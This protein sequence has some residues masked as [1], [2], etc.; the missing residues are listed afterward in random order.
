[1][2]LREVDCVNKPIYCPSLIPHETTLVSCCSLPGDAVPVLLVD[3]EI[4]NHWWRRNVATVPS[5]DVAPCSGTCSLSAAMLVLPNDRGVWFGSCC[6]IAAV[7][8][9]DSACKVFWWW[10]VKMLMLVAG[11]PIEWVEMGFKMC[12]RQGIDSLTP[13]AW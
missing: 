10:R 6:Q 12:A 13:L 2:H 4:L 5:Q 7:H 1:M 3:R 11:G 8:F 9:A